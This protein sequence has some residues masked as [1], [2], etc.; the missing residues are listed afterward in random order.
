MNPIELRDLSLNARLAAALHAFA[1]YCQKKNLADLQIDRFIEHLWAW[2]NV[3]TTDDSEAWQR[4]CVELLF[5]AMGDPMDSAFKEKLESR[6]LSGDEF[7]SLLRHIVEIIYGS[8]NA[9]A[10]DRQS[11]E[12]LEAVL[13]FAASE[14]IRPP[15]I[16]AF[17]NSRFADNHGWGKPLTP[18]EIKAWKNAI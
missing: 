6:G 4:H 1:G 16:A 8:F 17:A 18:S 14:G 11:L 3:R 5:A 2:L 10:D 15:P 12:D 7:Q 13:Q 9:A